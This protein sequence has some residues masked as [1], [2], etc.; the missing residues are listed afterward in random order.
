[1][2]SKNK[3]KSNNTINKRL[4]KNKINR[5][6]LNEKLSKEKQYSKK[7]NHVIIIILQI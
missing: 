4:N 5:I 2:N 7:K 6:N 3:S 1:M